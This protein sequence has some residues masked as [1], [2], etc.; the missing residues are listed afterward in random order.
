MVNSPNSVAPEG[1]NDQDHF[2]KQAG[3]WTVF[4]T[5]GTLLVVLGLL[6]YAMTL[7]HRTDPIVHNLSFSCSDTECE[8]S[9]ARLQLDQ[10]AFDRRDQRVQSA[11]SS[12]LMISVL[13]QLAALTLIVLGG[14]LVFDR[15]QSS[16]EGV[17][18]ARTPQGTEQDRWGF[19]LLT[20]FPG[21]LLCLMGVVTLIAAIYFSS[22]DA[23]RIQVTDYPVFSGGGPAIIL[24]NGSTGIDKSINLSVKKL[25]FP[26][27]GED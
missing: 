14:A 22:R 1:I 21:V 15:I 26:D 25:K 6:A 9:K 16:G 8:L 19:V 20:A 7:I 23:N 12:R 18:I 27:A 24:T 17:H 2:S 3:K 4:M 5:A 11:L 13:A 10:R